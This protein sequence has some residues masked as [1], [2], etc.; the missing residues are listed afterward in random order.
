MMKKLTFMVAFTA[1]HAFLTIFM[2]SWGCGHRFA[3]SVLERVYSL[4]VAIFMCPVVLP[5]VFFDPD[6]D[7]TPRWFQWSS[8]LV[9]SLIWAVVILLLLA[10]V[11]R[12]SG[13]REVKRMASDSIGE[14]SS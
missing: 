10:A 14:S 1:G 13:N 12:L 6:G 3:S 9:N 11:K 4:V 5:L 7:R 2:I 8:Y